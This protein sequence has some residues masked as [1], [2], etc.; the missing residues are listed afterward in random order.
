MLT[1]Y[2]S[3]NLNSNHLCGMDPQMISPA[4]LTVNVWP[5]LKDF[6]SKPRT[7][8]PFSESG[9]KAVRGKPIAM[10][11]EPVRKRT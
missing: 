7:R 10:Y 8:L 2:K 3:K 6:S 1:Y 4:W 5:A 11:G 9:K